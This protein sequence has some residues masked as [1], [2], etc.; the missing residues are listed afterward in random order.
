M[1]SPYWPRELPISLDIFLCLLIFNYFQLMVLQCRIP[2]PSKA[3]HFE[4]KGKGK[5]KGKSN[6]AL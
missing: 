5:G 6:V 4:G 1:N 3:H 2:F